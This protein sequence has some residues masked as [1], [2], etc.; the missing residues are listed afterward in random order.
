MTLGANILL[1]YYGSANYLGGKFIKMYALHCRAVLTDV[2]RP[3]SNPKTKMEG[4]F[5]AEEASELLKRFF[6]EKRNLN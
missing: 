5:L 3:K 6:I 2:R 4:S 1:I